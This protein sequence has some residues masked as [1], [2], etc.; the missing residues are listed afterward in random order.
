MTLCLALFEANDYGADCT[1]LQRFQHV[2]ARKTWLES[3]PD[4]E[5]R[6]GVSQTSRRNTV[7]W[8]GIEDA[9]AAHVR[10]DSFRA[11][12]TMAAALG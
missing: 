10:V 6:R 11:A 3:G 5:R 12:S 9:D 2:N 1:S 4:P 8:D 7:R